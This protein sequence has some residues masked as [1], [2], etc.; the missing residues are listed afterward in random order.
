VT[1]LV[2][3]ASGVAGRV[4][5]PGMVRAGH[6]VL[7]HLRAERR[8]DDVVS[9]LGASPVRGEVED[10]AQLARWL[11]R[12]EAVVDLRV[13]ILPANRAALPWA[14]REYARLR[15]HSCSQ[16]VDAA[17]G[18]GVSQAVHDTVAGFDMPGHG[19]RDA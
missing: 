11:C 13:A 17:M 5:L 6:E 19:G 2:L 3:G 10:P 8:A 9:A 1:I 18:S 12:C 4:A 16:L 15:N 7:A 14:R